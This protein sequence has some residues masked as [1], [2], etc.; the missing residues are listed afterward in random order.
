M[1][2][3]GSWTGGWQGKVTVTAGST[4]ISSWKLT[5]TWPGSQAITSAWNA[6]WSQTGS[7][8]TAANVSWNGAVAAGQSREAFGFIANGAT[9]APQ[10]TCTA[11]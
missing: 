9:A 10:V 1:S 6:T 3:V 2:T 5:W 8:V 4:A 7:A 11:T